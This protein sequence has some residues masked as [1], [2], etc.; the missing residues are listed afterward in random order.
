MKARIG[1]LLWLTVA[2]LF[3]GAPL[4]FWAA[5]AGNAPAAPAAKPVAPATQTATVKETELNVLTLTGD[6]ERRLDLKV[7]KIAR[8]KLQGARFLAGELVLPSGRAVTV[9]APFAGRVQSAGDVAVAPGKTLKKGQRVFT[10]LPL[11]T[12]EARTSMATTLVDAEGQVQSAGVQL[13]AAEVALGRA[14][15]LLSE[16]AGTQRAADEAQAAF[17][18]AQKNREGAAARREQIAKALKGAEADEGTAID[19]ESAESGMVRGVFVAPGQLV[20]AGTAL[21]EVMNPETLWVRVPA[22][23]GE[24]NELAA[25][26]P[27]S[28]TPLGGGARQGVRAKPIVAPPSASAAGATVDLFY[29]LD[30]A[31][32]AWVPGQRVAIT[33]P[34]SAEQEALTVA[35]SAVLHDVN[36]AGWVYENVGPRQYARRRVEVRYVTGPTAVLSAG[37]EDG[38]PVVTQG[39]AELFGR[40]MGHAK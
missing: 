20:A 39:A 17:E 38:T 33:V 24:L 7:G 32:G 40:E 30:N 34:M 8:Q 14:K 9:S 3:V 37:P 10:L 13:R 29:Q 25:D 15:R 12:T 6:A 26:Q 21:F 4:A 5:R 18:L 35:W 2:L 19:I 27:A 16:Q 36:G 31:D 1:S 11:L 23:A 28:V 22:Y